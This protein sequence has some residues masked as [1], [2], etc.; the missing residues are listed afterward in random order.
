VKKTKEE[1]RKIVIKLTKAVQT[2]RKQM[3]ENDKDVEK[4]NTF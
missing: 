4:E 3:G 1:R 2:N